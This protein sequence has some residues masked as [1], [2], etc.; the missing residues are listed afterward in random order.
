MDYISR[1]GY[2][3]FSQLG[4]IQLV[5][6][7][8]GALL[9]RRSHCVIVAGRDCTLPGFQ[10]DGYTYILP[11]DWFNW[12]QA[13]SSSQ[14]DVRCRQLHLFLFA[15]GVESYFR[16]CMETNPLQYEDFRQ[17]FYRHLGQMQPREEIL[18]ED[19]EDTRSHYGWN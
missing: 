12:L 1:S 19:R 18:A 5:E 8:P 7:S 9:L 10:F 2:A 15:V 14:K 13:R 4:E 11:S 3:S 6:L 16:T 17:I